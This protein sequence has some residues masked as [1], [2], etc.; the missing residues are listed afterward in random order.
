MAEFDQAVQNLE[1]FIGL[2]VNATSAVGQV[3]DHVAENGRLFGE[4]EHDAEEG[5]GGLNDRLEELATTLESEESETVTA[6]GEVTAAGNDATQGA[7]EVETKVEQAASDLEQVADAVETQLEQANTQLANEGFEPLDQALDEAQTELES[8]AQE[9]EQALTELATEIGTFETETE[10]AWN[11]AEAELDSSTTAMA[12]EETE[13][14]AEAQE[15]VQ[16]LERR[17]GRAGGRPPEPGDG[18]RRDLRRAGRGR[19]GPG[20]GPGAG[21]G[22]RGAGGGHLRQRCHQ[23]RVESSATMVDDEALGP[24]NQET[25]RCS[26]DRRGRDAARRPG[27]AVAELVR[28]QS[29][30]GQIDALMNGRRKRGGDPVT[31]LHEILPVLDE[32]APGPP[33]RLAEVAKVGRVPP[34]G[35]GGG[36]RAQ[37]RRDQAETLVAQVRQ[38]LEALREKRAGGAKRVADASQALGDMA[39]EHLRELDQVEVQVTAEGEQARTAL[40]ELSPSWKGAPSGPAPPTRRRAPP[41]SARRGGAEPRSR[42]DAA[43]DAMNQAVKTAQQA[44]ADGQ[45]LA[46][47]GAATPKGAMDRLLGEAQYRLTQTTGTSPTSSPRR[48]PR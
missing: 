5:G 30:V 3:E 9:T 8:Q 21:G 16:G 42:V 31:S 24:L 20:P 38:A 39:E 2:V 14:E 35:G 18:G 48:R 29:V 44:I 6:I 32:A 15:G 27:A 10:A 7:G 13:I 1:R 37:A 40:G 34:G 43:V 41:G 25:R 4:L 12:Q 33:S 28:A 45:D 46:E 23:Q 26:P 47:Q 19:C 22:C 11:E 36:G 17:R